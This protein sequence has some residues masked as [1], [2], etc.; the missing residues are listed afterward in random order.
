MDSGDSS[1]GTSAEEAPPGPVDCARCSVTGSGFSGGAAQAPAQLTIISKD[2]S[3]R[4]LL[5]GGC[6]VFVRVSAAGGNAPEGSTIEVKATDNSDGTYSANYVVPSRGNYNLS[7]A[8][9]GTPIGGSPFPVFFSPPETGAAAASA[10]LAADQD[11]GQTE[12][13]LAAGAPQLVGNNVMAAEATQ[14]LGGAIVNSLYVSNI[15]AGVTLE[16]LKQLFSY[17]GKIQDMRYVGPNKDIVTVEYTTA[18]VR[19]CWELCRNFAHKYWAW[20]IHN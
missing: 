6:D 16:Q 13:G 9:N 18:L 3:G 20:R 14:A 12:G 8:I 10:G 2:A 1:S 7:I 4:R 5:H 19:C 15:N 11:L 17:C